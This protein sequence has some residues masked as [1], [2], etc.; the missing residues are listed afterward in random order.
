M[1]QTAMPPIN[2][3][4]RLGVPTPDGVFPVMPNAGGIR[5]GRRPMI[6]LSLHDLKIKM[7]D[8]DDLLEA[9]WGIIANANGGDWNKASPEWRDAAEKWR[10]RYHAKRQ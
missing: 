8:Q 7:G 5:R 4:V 9:A 6:D 3:A 2:P 1:E 10:D